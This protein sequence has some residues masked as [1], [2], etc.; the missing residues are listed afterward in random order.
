MIIDDKIQKAFNQNVE[1]VEKLGKS[2]LGTTYLIVHPEYGQ[3]C[4]K[5]LEGKATENKKF[6]ERFFESLQECKKVLHPN[7]GKI[8]SLIQEETFA[9]VREKAEGKSLQQILAQ[10]KVFSIQE[11]IN[12]IK[13]ITSGLEAIHSQGFT[14]KN[15]KASNI[16]LQETK[17]KIV[18]S[19]LPPTAPQYLSPE[20]CKGKKSDIRS[21]IYSL[22]VLFYYLLI[23]ETPYFAGTAKDIMEAHVQ[24][25]CPDMQALRNDVPAELQKLIHKMLSKKPAMRPQ[26][27]QELLAF[28]NRIELMQYA[29]AQEK[30]F[31]KTQAFSKINPNNQTQGIPKQEVPASLEMEDNE[32]TIQLVSVEEPPEVASEKIKKLKQ[33]ASDMASKLKIVNQ[34]LSMLDSVQDSQ[35]LESIL[36]LDEMLRF[37]TMKT[38]ELLKADRTIIYLLD[39]ERNELL[40]IVDKEEVGSPFELKLPSNVGIVG[41]VVSNKKA[42]NI[43]YDFYKDPRSASRRIM[44]TKTN[45]RTYNMLAL[46]VLDNQGDTVAVLQLLNKLKLIHDPEESLAEQVDLKGF[47]EKDHQLFKEF[48][49]SIR[50]I[51]ESSRSFYRATQR[52]RAAASLMSSIQTLSKGSLELDETLKLV[53]N[54]ARQLIEAD[55]ITLWMLDKEKKELW[56]NIPMADGKIKEIRIPENAGFAGKV[57]QSKQDLMIPFDLY[58]HPESETA[59][60]TDQ[61]TGYRTCSLLCVPVF[62]SNQEL[63]GVTQ[64]I[65]KK[66]KGDFPVYDPKDWPNPP[67]CWKTSFNKL[68]IDFMQAFNIQAGVA[69]Q[70]AK[71][72]A[73]IKQQEQ[74]QRD[75]LRSLSNGVIS[76]D[77]NGIVIATNDSAKRLLG[78]SLDEKMEGMDI[79]KILTIKERNFGSCLDS[80]M[81]PKE[82]KS[83]AQ[84]YPEQTLILHGEKQHNINL[85]INSIIDVEDP[86]KIC[87]ALVVMEDISGEKR[88]K[89]MMYRYM[90]QEVVD[91][92]LNS[93]DIKLGGQK[94]EVTVFFSDIR[95]YTTLT[96]GMQAEE[97]VAMLNEYF[98]VMVDVVFKYRGTL[99]KYIGDALMVVFG[100]PLPLEGHGWYAVQTALEMRKRLAKFNEIR[101]SQKKKPIKIGIGIHTDSVISGNIGSSKRM[102][103][104]SIGDGVNLA[105]RLEGTTKQYGCDIIIS[106]KTYKTC[107]NLIHAR[108]LDFI[109]VKGKTEPVKIYEVVGLIEEELPSHKKSLLE[110]YAQGRDLYTSR[111]FINAIQKFQEVL[112]VDPGNVAAQMHIERCQD[113]LIH[114]PKEDWNGVWKLT[115]K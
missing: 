35:G 91:Q 31:P 71:L 38:G 104:T 106:E 4:L 81:S 80:A 48:E 63:I 59:K 32:C 18:D 102:E 8:Y 97:V 55:R 64:L 61:I 40:P 30:T 62:N 21:D 1:I 5:L 79:R 50:L 98:E 28:L 84:Y 15:L 51:L 108:E 105:S 23:G 110:N 77:K 60:K 57:V 101:E 107:S 58:E 109:V 68:D 25:P 6:L 66:R 10:Q 103:L 34:T 73:T 87:G 69:L 113:F 16:F 96:E 3:C 29:F 17:I 85:S 36:F 52:Q 112:A 11:S 88:I 65:N 94:K 75:I 67:D 95:S 9:I 86:E 49:P 44:D 56:A 100:S 90:T 7:L 45:Y 13:E 43:P 27:C 22:G 24:S 41:E 2:S 26:S 39:E 12:I 99:D 92:L 114:P 72:F 37:I 33:V 115:E 93:E 78:L 82:E 42:I 46:P 70:N 54:E 20:Q 89:G 14:H 111:N 76:T 19:S 74:M 47:T 83:K 53:M